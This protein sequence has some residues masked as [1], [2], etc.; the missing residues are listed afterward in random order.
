M[1][2]TLQPG[3]AMAS[4]LSSR[5]ASITKLAT[6]ITAPALQRLLAQHPEPLPLALDTERRVIGGEQDRH[7]SYYAD[8]NQ[9]GR[10]IVLIHGIHAAAS[11]YDVRPLFD[12]YR[13][14]RP[15]YA[16][17]LP[18][19]G[20]SGRP[21][22]PYSPAIYVDAVLDLLRHVAMTNLPAD[23]VAL[24]LSAEFAA[25]AAHINPELVHSLVLISPTGFST[26]SL[27]GLINR[28]LA[29]VAHR[30]LHRELVGKNTHDLLVT[31]PAIHY[32]LRKFFHGPVDK[33]LQKYCF[34]T[35][36][37]PGAWHA[38]MAFLSGRLFTRNVRRD[39]YAAVRVPVLVVYDKDPYTSFGAL[40]RFV[41]D[42]D[43]WT[44]QRLK[45]S[46]GLPHFDLPS[47]TIGALDG[48]WFK[49]ADRKIV[50]DQLRSQPAN[51][52]RIRLND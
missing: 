52:G 41:R 30:V 24:S 12:H 45:P 7:V 22:G 40:H 38:P 23:I 26:P 13:T 42:H 46:R 37:Q 35:A 29:E 33:G 36:H 15:V 10:P 44:A 25:R 21:P 4:V 47:Q 6:D 39:V 1:V 5:V 8:T 49:E 51:G 50:A 9:P 17:D 34:A 32:F 28:G 27:E 3:Q 2:Q 18:G 14:R 19:F 48:F 43:N 11:A 31:R 16:I 20:F